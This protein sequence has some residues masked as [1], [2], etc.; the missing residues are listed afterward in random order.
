MEVNY[1][2]T[3]GMCRAFAP[4][5]IARKAGMIVN[6]CSIIGMVNMPANG[7]YCASKAAVHSLTQ[8]LRGEMAPHGVKVL[9]VYPGPVETRMTEGLEMPKT[10]PD[11]VAKAIVDGMAEA[12]PTITPDPM[13]SQ[14]YGFLLKDYESAEKELGAVLPGA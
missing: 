1:F 13:S 11:A 4:L 14:L 2:G 10:S 9:G 12:K 7:T 3:L 8:G 5:F 6:V